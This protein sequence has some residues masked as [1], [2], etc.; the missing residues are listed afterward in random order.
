MHLCWFPASEATAA[1][2]RDATV[3]PDASKFVID[4]GGDSHRN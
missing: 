4:L 1:E 3:L 2:H